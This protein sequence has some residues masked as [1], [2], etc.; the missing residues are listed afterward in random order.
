LLPRRL[1]NYIPKHVLADLKIT[2]ANI[3]DLHKVKPTRLQEALA[4][5]EKK[6]F[7]VPADVG[8]G[9]LQP[10]VDGKVLPTHP[11][12]PTAPSYLPTYPFMVGTCRNEASVAIGN[13]GIENLDEEGLKKRKSPKNIKPRAT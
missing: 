4:V 8:R 9:G 12:D 6:N 13:A 10:V 3:A 2:K 11:F 1:L 5:A 7:K